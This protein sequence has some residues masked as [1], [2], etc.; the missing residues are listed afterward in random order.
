MEEMFGITL[1]PA[2]KKARQKCDDRIKNLL[3][4]LTNPTVFAETPESERAIKAIAT[5]EDILS[6]LNKLAK[7]PTKITQTK[8]TREAFGSIAE[9]AAGKR[10]AIT[11]F[12]PITK[13]EFIELLNQAY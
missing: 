5:V 8:I 1:V 12:T 11:A 7:L 2:I 6:A 3:L 4:S 9:A 10:A 13:E